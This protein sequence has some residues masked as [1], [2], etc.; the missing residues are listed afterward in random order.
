MRLGIDASNLR[1]G[2]GVT[3]LGELLRAAEPHQHG[4]TRVVV[5]AGQRTLRRMPARPWL[6][7]VHERMLDL[8]LPFRLY[9]RR[10]RL[11]RLAE[12]ACDVLFV[13]GGGYTGTVK[14]FVVMSRNLLPFESA[15]MRRYGLSWMLMRLLLLRLAHARSF[16]RADGVIFLTE[17]ARSVVLGQ[18]KGVNGRWTIIPHGIDGRFARPPRRQKPVGAYSWSDPLKCLYVSIVDVYKHQW[19][20]AEAVATLR[21]KGIPVVLDLVGPAYPAALR[22]LRQVVRRIDPAE[23]FIRYCGYVPYSALPDCYHGADLFVFASSCENMPNILLEAMAAGLPIAS[24]ER[25]PMLEILGEAGVY[26]D[27]EEPEGIA[28]SL[29]SLIEDAGLRERCAALAYERAKNFSW[30]RCARETLSFL[31][32]VARRPSSASF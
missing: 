15:E 11:P 9:W 32:D 16:C 30:E 7:G 29:R 25:G 3:H 23:E 10:A 20:V 24:S 5:W 22:H 19:H 12:R 21:R 13:P 26:F 6:E 31:V 1:V 8:S 18:V 4:I 17:Y 28:E 14:P 27:H 2:G